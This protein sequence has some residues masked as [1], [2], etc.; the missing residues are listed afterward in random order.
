MRTGLVPVRL[1]LLLSISGPILLPV[2]V[3]VR[4][5]LRGG[6]EDVVPERTD[7]QRRTASGE[8]QRS[9]EGPTSNRSV[10]ALRGGVHRGAPPGEPPTRIG[11]QGPRPD[12]DSQQFIGRRALPATHTGAYR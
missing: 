5:P 11:D 3:P 1:V 8:A 6:A 9:R 7:L 2:P 10:Q 4:R 12:D